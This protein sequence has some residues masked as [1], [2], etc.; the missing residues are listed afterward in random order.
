[1]VADELSKRHKASIIITGSKADRE[2]AK[3]I[4]LKMSHQPI[5]TSGRFSLTQLTALIK[6]C[7]LYIT[8]DTA[9]MHIANAL[10]IPLVAI[11]GPGTMKTAPYQKNNCIVLKKDVGCSPCYKFKCKDMRCLKGITVDEVIQ[12]SE[13]LLK[14]YVKN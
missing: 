7:H 11:M 13:I 5:D 8:N 14:D 10:K 3:K 9:P 2:L 6:R 12:A 1:M 4:S